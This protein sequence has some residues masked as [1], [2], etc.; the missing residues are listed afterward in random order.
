MA[1]WLGSVELG[2]GV[3]EGFLLLLSLTWCGKSALE[4]GVSLEGVGS[5]RGS[6]QVGEMAEGCK[7]GY[8][9]VVLPQRGHTH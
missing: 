9:A 8:L 2:L 6:Q 7:W 5:Q 4:A 3:G 1:N